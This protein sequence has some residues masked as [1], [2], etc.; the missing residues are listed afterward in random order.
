MRK[1]TELFRAYLLTQLRSP[2]ETL[3][4]VGLV[5]AVLIFGFVLNQDRTPAVV[6]AYSV[7]LVGY[8]SSVML[9]M[10]ISRDRESGLY[11]MM[12][13]TRMSKLDYV[14]GKSAIVNS[15]AFL[16]AAVFLAAG[17]GMYDMAFRPLEVSA[18]MVLTAFSH[19]GIGLVVAAFL[20]N[21][22]QVQFV[23][24]VLMMT[25]VVVAPVFYSVEILPDA[26]KFLPRAVPLTYSIEAVQAVTVNGGG[27]HHI[28]V[29]V[30]VLVVS[31]FITAFI[32]YRRL[33]Y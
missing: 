4:T 11:R 9:P 24:S 12:R 19:A 20:E 21:D 1:I 27:V 25:M 2:L 3:G 30:S 5:V 22:K 15:G 7:F 18:V 33:D 13:T 26:L 31:G 10:V 14:L 29:P 6:A 16:F 23:S 8:A 28:I 32:G 17:Y